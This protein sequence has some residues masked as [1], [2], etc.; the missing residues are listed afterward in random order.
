[1]TISS[2]KVITSLLR[3]EDVQRDS[4]IC[5]VTWRAMRD[6]GLKRTRRNH[7]DSCI[8]RSYWW[9]IVWASQRQPYFSMRYLSWTS[10]YKKKKRSNKWKLWGN[11]WKQNRTQL[12][13]WTTFL[14]KLFLKNMFTSHLL[15]FT[16]SW[17]L[18][19]SRWSLLPC[20]I[21][22]TWVTT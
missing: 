9:R 15:H 17:L 14:N 20:L 3:W 12:T 4:T 2:T 5:A 7:E 19:S 11:T 18:C 13:I 10:S 8:F 1:M 22:V 6:D 16:N 21:G